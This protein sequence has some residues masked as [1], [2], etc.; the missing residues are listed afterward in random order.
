LARDPGWMQPVGDNRGGPNVNSLT[1]LWPHETSYYC[2]TTT[3]S[4][5][6]LPNTLTEGY[7]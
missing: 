1:Y 7:K 4:T 3:A 6:A 2:F 5:F